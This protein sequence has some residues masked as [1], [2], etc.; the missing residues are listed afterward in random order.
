MFVKICGITSSTAVEAAVAAGADA[1]GFV[2]APSVR[3]V[4]P[5]RAAELCTGLPTSIVRVAVT[6][7]PAVELWARICE[8]FAPDWLQSDAGDFADLTVPAGCSRLPVLRDGFAPLGVRPERVLFE[9]AASGSGNIANWDEARSLARATKL[10]LAG[11]L[12]AGNVERAI[13]HVRPWGVDVSSGV[14]RRRGEKDPAKIK[15]FVAR[16]RA[17]EDE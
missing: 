14:E 12:N 2:F 8:V 17:L 4:T 7:H 15:E 3:E 6:R 16:V 1:L 5:E 11:G 9:G 13:R 10:I